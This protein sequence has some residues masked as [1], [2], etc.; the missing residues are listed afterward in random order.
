MVIDD[1]IQHPII[2]TLNNT[3]TA[4]E[5]HGT[6]EKMK[7]NKDPGLSGVMQTCLKTYLKKELLYS[8]PTSE[9]SGKTKSATMSP[10]TKRN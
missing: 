6:I 10:G 7:N 4:D 3:P 9:N 1:L 8:L 2:S 5:I